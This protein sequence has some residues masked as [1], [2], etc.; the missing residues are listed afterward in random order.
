M[1][2]LVANILTP[3]VITSDANAHLEVSGVQG[4]TT[5]HNLADR[6]LYR[7]C[8]TQ[9]VYCTDYALHSVC[10]V[11]T[12]HCT[13]YALHSMCTVQTM[14]YTVCVL[15]RLCTTQYVYCTDYAL[16]LTIPIVKERENIVE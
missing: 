8:T 9:Y 16:W 4:Q 11:H 3:F 12:V 15:Y 2:Y 6:E 14:H 1:N 13:D 7:L 5:G 10:T